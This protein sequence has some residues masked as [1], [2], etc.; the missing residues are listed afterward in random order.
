MSI[1]VR[2]GAEPTTWAALWAAAPG[3]GFASRRRLR[4]RSVGVAGVGG[5]R[6]VGALGQP[7]ERADQVLGQLAVAARVEQHLL[8][9]PVGVVV[10]EDRVVEVALAPGRLQVAGGG[11]DRVHRVVGVLA[12]VA[13]GVDPVGG[14]GRGDEL[15]PAHR[16]GAGDVEVGA[17]GGLDLVDRGQHLPGDVV[18]GAAG[19]VDRQQEGRDLEGVDDE[20]GDPEGGGAERGEGGRGG[21]RRRSAAGGGARRTGSA[22]SARCWCR[23]PAPPRRR[24]RGAR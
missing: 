3:A 16:P 11:A 20:V 7:G 5:D 19:L 17:E 10:G 23:S 18:L 14:P 2:P 22:R 13:V 8:H 4:S 9:V 15:H 21:A 1:P 24:S 6:E 12:P